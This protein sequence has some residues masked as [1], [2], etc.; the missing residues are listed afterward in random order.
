MSLSFYNLIPS[1]PNCNSSS[2]G[3]AVFSLATH[4][5]PYIQKSHNPEFDFH[6]M[7]NGSDGWELEVRSHGGTP[8]DNMIK[9]FKLEE[10]Y[11]THNSLEVQDIMDLITHNSESYLKTLFNQVQ[12]VFP[13]LS[14]EEVI[15]ML[16]GFESNA[17]KLDKRPLSKL[18]RDLLKNSGVI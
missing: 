4:I 13:R 11:A 6:A 18:K 1:C 16:L 9:A 5:H 15:R 10:L 12:S 7:P 3:S 2:K 14:Q 17:E 8:V